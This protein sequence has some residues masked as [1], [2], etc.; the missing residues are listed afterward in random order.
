MIQGLSTTPRLHRLERLYQ[1]LLAEFFVL[2][3]EGKVLRSDV[4]AVL[5]KQKMQE[6]LERIVR[7]K[8]E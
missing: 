3:R 1:E 8:V 7:T 6:I 2:E 5:D 4:Q